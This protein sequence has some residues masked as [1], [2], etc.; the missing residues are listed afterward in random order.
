LKKRVDE[1]EQLEQSIFDDFKWKTTQIDEGCLTNA[2]RKLFNQMPKIV[3]SANPE[4]ILEGERLTHKNIYYIIRRGLDLFMNS[5]RIQLIDY[6]DKF[7]FWIRFVDFVSET[8]FILNRNRGSQIIQERILGKNADD[9][10]ENENDPIWKKLEDADKKWCRD[11]KEFWDYSIPTM[12]KIF[13]WI[14][15][16]S[17]EGE[18]IEG[19]EPE[20]DNTSTSPPRAHEFGLYK[21]FGEI[22]SR[23]LSRSSKLDVL[24]F[25]ELSLSNKSKTLLEMLTEQETEQKE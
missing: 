1:I 19:E 5:M 14:R 6:G 9:W 12:E 20:I 4:E 23:C 18:Y 11:F 8:M 21:F 3:V 7:L 16:R 2:E 25:V 24:M 15:F 22:I 10:P 17:Q 13:S